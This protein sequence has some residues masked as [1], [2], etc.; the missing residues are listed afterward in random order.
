MKTICET[1]GKEFNI[2]PSRLKWGRGKNCS[3]TCQSISVS[4][5]LTKEKIVFTCLN[6]GN[7]F[8][9]LECQLKGKKNAGKWC[10][11]SCR[12]E[13]RKGINHPYYIG[14]RIIKRGS[15]WQ[16]Q[17]RKALKRDNFTC[18]KCGKKEFINVHHIKP[19]RFFNGD[20]KTANN[21][22]NLIC[23]CS[24]CHRK[25]DALIQKK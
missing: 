2:C 3:K 9:L 1:C 15:N 10:C 23:L 18:Q 12:D 13:Y 14:E 17:K 20:Y 11:R 22:S 7:H 21:L 16:S 8:N 25:A 5:K 4:K 6:C 24:A 19:Y